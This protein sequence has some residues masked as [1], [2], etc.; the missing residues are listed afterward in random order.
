MRDRSVLIFALAVPLALMAVFNLVFG[1]STR[2]E[3]EPVT[4]AVSV[5]GRGRARP[6][7]SR[8]TLAGLDVVDVTLPT[9]PRGRGRGTL[10]GLG[11]GGPRP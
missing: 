1:G 10:G 6:G 5:P 11:D 2:I 8:R 9:A 7:R 3:L 4:V